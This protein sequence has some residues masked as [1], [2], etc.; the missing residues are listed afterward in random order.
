MEGRVEREFTVSSVPADKIW[1]VWNS[2]EPD[3]KRAVEKAFGEMTLGDVRRRLELGDMTLWLVWE[4]G[5]GTAALKGSAV[6]EVL[7]YPRLTAVRITLLG[8]EEMGLWWQFLLDGLE[9]YSRA[10]K[11]DRLEAVGRK[12]L[13]RSLARMGFKQK[14]VVMVK[15]VNNGQNGRYGNNQSNVSPRVIPAT[16]H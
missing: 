4:G 1:H 11:A 10:I 14:Y 12:G 3:L 5:P 15:E 6:T 13:S 7:S 9:S 16:V 8:G 2:V